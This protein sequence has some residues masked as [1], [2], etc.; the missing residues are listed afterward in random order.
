MTFPSEVTGEDRGEPSLSRRFLS[1]GGTILLIMAWAGSSVVAQTSSS[2]PLR[3]VLVL[4]SDERLLPANIIA[5]EAI[6]AT[7][8]ARH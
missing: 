4:Y 1:L 2:M 7:F 6:R 5:D 8:A 3:R